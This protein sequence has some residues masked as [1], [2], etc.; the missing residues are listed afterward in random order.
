MSSPSRRGWLNPIISLTIRSDVIG[1]FHEPYGAIVT[2]GPAFFANCF[3]CRE[4]DYR[5]KTRKCKEVR[6]ACGSGRLMIT[7]EATIKPPATAGGSDKKSKGADLPQSRRH[8][9]SV[10]VLTRRIKE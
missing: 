8:Y 1:D 7:C 6:T 5:Q 10:S 3:E 2:V 4:G 9:P